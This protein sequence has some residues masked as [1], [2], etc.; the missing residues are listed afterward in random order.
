MFGQRQVPC[1]D[2]FLNV[3]F[4]LINPD[5]KIGHHNQICLKSEPIVRFI[6]GLIRIILRNDMKLP[7]LACQSW[8]LKAWESFF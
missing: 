3:V 6:K 4:R 8:C 5:F 7:F 1:Y 2:S